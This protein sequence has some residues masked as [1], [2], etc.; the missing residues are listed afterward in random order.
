ML[1]NSE[2]EYELYKIIEKGNQQN[3]SGFQLRSV[4]NHSDSWFRLK[5]QSKALLL[6]KEFS[7]NLFI[8]RVS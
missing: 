3:C 8:R 2:Y 4:V 6:L 7:M 5:N 1:F